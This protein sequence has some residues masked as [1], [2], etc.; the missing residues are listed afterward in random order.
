MLGSRHYAVAFLS[1]YSIAEQYLPIIS[2]L[3]PDTKILIDTV[4]IHFVRE[5]REAQLSKDPEALKRAAATKQAELAIYSR[6][7][8]LI[9]KSL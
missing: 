1:F 3:S 2:S 9:T 8:A 6:A 4:D 5:A 7:D